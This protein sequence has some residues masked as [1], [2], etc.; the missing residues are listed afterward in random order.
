MAVPKHINSKY[1]AIIFEDTDGL[2][3]AR[4]STTGEVSLT[5]LSVDWRV[6][7]LDVGD[8]AIKLPAIPFLGRNSLE[9]HNLSTTVTLFVGPTDDVT[10]D[11]VNGT[12]S[13]KEIPPNS[14]WS[15]DITDEIELYGICETSYST[16]IKITE[17]A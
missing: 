6:T 7:T 12:T 15:I 17:V 16:K 13:G 11:R 10:A 1:S 14:F 4:T 8:T 2:I 3:K 5:G 9:I